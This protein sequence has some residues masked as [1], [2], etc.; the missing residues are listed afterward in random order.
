MSHPIPK[1]SHPAGFTL[2]ELLVVISIIA[3]LIGILLPVLSAARASARLI[4]CKSNLKQ[5]GI[6]LQTYTADYKGFLPYAKNFGF[7]YASEDPSMPFYQ[8]VMEPFIEGNLPGVSV[9]GAFRCPSIEAGNGE[10]FLQS[11]TA[12]HYRYNTDM[13]IRYAPVMPLSPPT[14]NLA[15]VPSPSEARFSYDVAFN[16]WI[17]NG[18]RNGSQFAHEQAGVAVNAAY[19]DGHVESFT[20]EEYDEMTG[21]PNDFD[22]EFITEGWSS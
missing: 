20:I 21:P 12:S 8:D 19:L 22:D 10:A 9:S 3:L 15:T 5:Q 1:R 7:Q 11:P 14:T 17:D 18:G 6:G 16:D 13:A 4:A 2:I